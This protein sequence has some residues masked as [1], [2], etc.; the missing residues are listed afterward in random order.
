[1]KS[2]TELEAAY[3]A[4]TYRV[5]LPQG[6]L[7]LRL[8]QVEPVLQQWL[9]ARKISCFAL[10]TAH[11]PASENCTPEDNA[12]WQAQLECE[13]LEGN[14]EPYATEHCAD[15]DA[16]PVEEGCF[17]P[18]LQAEDALALAEAYGQLAVVVGGQDGVPR[19]AWTGLAEA[20]GT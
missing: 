8:D 6:L 19:L 4:T 11:N 20:A 1:M 12:D 3:R 2:R 14:Y 9:H 16:W 13:L 18:E 5:Y 17:V 10:L 15:A 7:E